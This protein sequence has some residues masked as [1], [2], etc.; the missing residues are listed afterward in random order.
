MGH[1]SSRCSRCTRAVICCGDNDDDDDRGMGS[2]RSA[3][4]IGGVDDGEEGMVELR[5]WPMYD[6]NG[7][8][9]DYYGGGDVRTI[10]LCRYLVPWCIA[11]LLTN[12]GLNC[13]LRLSTGG[14]FG[15]ALGTRSGRRWLFMF[16]LVLLVIGLSWT[17]YSRGR[18]KDAIIASPCYVCNPKRDAFDPLNDK[19]SNQAAL[20]DA[21]RALRDY[22]VYAHGTGC[23]LDDRW[24]AALDREAM[25]LWHN[26]SISGNETQVGPWT[27]YDRMLTGAMR[28]ESIT[29]KYRSNPS[30][31]SSADWRNT[32]PSVYVVGFRGAGTT[33]FWRYLDAHPDTLVRYQQPQTTPSMVAQGKDNN[34]KP[35]LGT[36]ATPWDDH[37]FAS[38][39][40]WTPDELRQWVR[41]GWGPAS[42]RDH[43][44]RGR[45]RI[46][47]GPDYLWL[48]SSG[49][50]ASVRRAS[51]QTRQRFV[52]L[53]A[54][55]V[56]LVR[57]AHD[58]AVQAGIET[59][60]SL[61]DV[62]ASELPRLARCLWWDQADPAEQDER[63]VSGLCGGA[64]PGRI[65]GPYL[66]RGL[67]SV[68]VAHWMRTVSPGQRRQW[69]FVRSEDL[70]HQP[71][72][73]LNRLGVDF[74]DLAP[75]DYGP[76]V[77]RLWHP[78]PEVAKTLV[79]S[80]P[81]H[82]SWKAYVPRMEFI[83]RA[84]KATMDA[85]LDTAS[86]AARKVVP[87]L[88]AALKTREKLKRLHC[89]LAGLFKEGDI[90]T[91]ASRDCL[92]DDGGHNVPS[93]NG[94]DAEDQTEPVDRELLAE[95]ALRDFYAPYQ[96]QLMDMIASI[97]EVQRR[98]TPDSGDD[99]LPG[100]AKQGNDDALR[101]FYLGETVPTPPPKRPNLREIYRRRKQERGKKQKRA[102]TV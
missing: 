28:P 8:Y 71:N 73:T 61:A 81:W 54:D 40:D 22:A 75:F 80:A 64:S 35:I 70:L 83:G 51:I 20:D 77:R 43:R 67:L 53:L 96:A 23:S 4:G 11:R 69:Y 74:L 14:L 10:H 98:Q 6:E 32:L 13:G 36:T 58:R 57:E 86:A 100:T 89:R 18:H 24:I 97:Q 52:V 102:R 45:L 99:T 26:H 38:V 37:F 33:S 48:A 79:P 93:S 49:A 34:K 59:R 42:V 39:P 65:G 60:T 2:L 31:T 3:Y 78:S 68:Y 91:G 84:R 56:R 63:L 76:H 46:E 90:P 16:T 66:W 9:P 25:R 12:M 30:G 55:P 95:A 72:R 88:D 101:G 94:G 5:C 29:K 15:W 17:T 85:L 41:R 27:R 92:Q 82:Q 1:T 7:E 87:G 19:R 21:T 62:V 50:P 47:V 44:G